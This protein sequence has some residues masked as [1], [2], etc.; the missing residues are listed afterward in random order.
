MLIP[1]NKH[2]VSFM[3]EAV[4]ITSCG[5]SSRKQELD[6]LAKLGRNDAIIIENRQINLFENIFNDANNKLIA[7]GQIQGKISLY[8]VNNPFAALYAYIDSCSNKD[9]VYN[10][11]YTIAPV[12]QAALVFFFTAQQDLPYFDRLFLFG[13]PSQKRNRHSHGGFT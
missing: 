10:I 8:S 1:Y 4:K 2:D 6:T 12:E 5:D 7:C 13:T 11:S 3:Q 9:T